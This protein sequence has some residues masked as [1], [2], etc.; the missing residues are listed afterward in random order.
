MDRD[1]DKNIESRN[2]YYDIV[3]FNWR[4]Y[5]LTDGEYVV[6]ATATILEDKSAIPL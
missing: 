5:G 3:S 2:T 4:T 1:R 6:R